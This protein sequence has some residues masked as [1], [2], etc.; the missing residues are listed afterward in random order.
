MLDLITNMFSTLKNKTFLL[1]D[2]EESMAK[3]SQ[4]NIA[5]KET[6]I[7]DVPQNKILIIQKQI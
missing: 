2:R 6:I 7:T 4:T 5:Q 1:K 3:I